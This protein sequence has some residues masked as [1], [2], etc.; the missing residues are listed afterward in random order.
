MSEWDFLWEVDGAEREFAMA[1]GLTYADLEYLI[2]HQERKRIKH[3]N[4]AWKELKKL[5]DRGSISSEEFKKRK[6]EVFAVEI[7]QKKRK[8]ALIKK[9]KA[10]HAHSTNN[11][12]EIK[13]SIRCACFGCESKVLVY[14]LTYDGD[15]AIC[16]H[17]GKK[18]I[19]P[20]FDDIEYYLHSMHNYYYP[21]E[22]S[23]EDEYEDY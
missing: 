20:F 23:D 14:N 21:N 3:R 16:P 6:C 12:D 18:A 13:G 19:I 4:E 9:L 5:R 15:T 22:K 1:T 2:E 11:R 10:F 17:C 8:K 7:E